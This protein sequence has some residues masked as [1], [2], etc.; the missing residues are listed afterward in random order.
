MEVATDYPEL[1]EMQLDWSQVIRHEL[2]E[3][4][5]SELNANK[6]ADRDQS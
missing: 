1:P 4:K 5:T 3:L 2:S 6:S